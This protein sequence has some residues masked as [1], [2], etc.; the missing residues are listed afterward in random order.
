MVMA[1]TIPSNIHNRDGDLFFSVIIPL[2]NKEPYVERALNS[3]L[4]QSFG[5][6]EI[7][8]VDDCSTDGGLVVVE[9]TLSIS[10]KPYRIIHRSKRGGSCAPTRA[11]G[12]RYARGKFVAFLDADDEWKEGF[13]SEIAQLIENF[14]GAEAYAVDRELHVAGR[15]EPG[16]Y[17]Q[18]SD[19]LDAHSID[20]ERYLFAREKFGNPFRVPGMVFS[21]EALDDIGGF[22]H[23]PRSSDIDL[24]FR[25]FISG[26]IAA[27]SP[28]QGLVIH[29]VPDSTMANTPTQV[30]RPW[31]YSVNKA[32]DRNV[33]SKDVIYR[34]RRD[35]FRQKAADVITAVRMKRLDRGY[36]NNLSFFRNPLFVLSSWF[37]IV[38]PFMQGG[39]A[40]LVL[41]VSKKI[42]NI[43]E[44]F[45]TKSKF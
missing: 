42:N 44:K 5:G 26:K 34:L 31:F 27:W 14:P 39:R 41:R 10:Q 37:L 13:L 28:Y 45:K 7:I 18:R 40:A 36:L 16:P 24:M 33:L 19:I 32:I 9:Q 12:L 8:V 1:S 20:L 4:G 23:A 30:T 11:T 15:V 35:V 38:M 3:V 21:P 43:V 17:G 25:F 22:V 29:R 6:F 2:Y